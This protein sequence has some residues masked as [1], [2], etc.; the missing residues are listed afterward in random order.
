M[1]HGNCA[2][3]SEQLVGFLNATTKAQP[4]VRQRSS[5]V[6]HINVIYV[7]IRVYIIYIHIYLFAEIHTYIHYITLH[8]STVQYSTLHYIKLHYI[9]LHY[10]HT[11]IYVRIQCTA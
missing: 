6:S 3:V 11:Y 4:Q 9:T 1:I 5:C 7:Y 8:Y 10:I 2:Q